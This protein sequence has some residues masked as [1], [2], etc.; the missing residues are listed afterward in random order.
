MRPADRGRLV[1]GSRV[2]DAAKASRTG[3][4][5]S[6]ED[7]LDLVSEKKV[8][9]AHDARVEVGLVVG[10]EPLPSERLDELRF[11][12]GSQCFGAM[13]EI[14]G[15]ALDE[16][17]LLNPMA[18]NIRHQFWAQIGVLPALPM[19]MVGVVD[20]EVRLAGRF[21][22]TRAPWVRHSRDFPRRAGDLKSSPEISRLAR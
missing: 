2:P 4:Q 7:R 11:A 10:P 14:S 12:H 6:F 13:V 19:V 8:G 18:R 9:K 17:R 20:E 5:V 22:H 1:P 16:N 21:I 15:A 3:G